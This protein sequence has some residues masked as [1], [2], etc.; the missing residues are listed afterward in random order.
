[1]TF[2]RQFQLHGAQGRFVV[3]GEAPSLC[4][5]RADPLVSFQ[6]VL[7]DPDQLVP[8]LQVADV[9][10]GKLRRGAARA[11]SGAAGVTPGQQLR[12]SRM[13]ID[14]PRAVRVKKTDRRRR[15]A[16]HR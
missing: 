4:D 11:E 5:Q 13:R 15:R 10:D 9:V 3:F 8:D 12:V 6:V 2:R 16:P 14:H 1:M 7:V